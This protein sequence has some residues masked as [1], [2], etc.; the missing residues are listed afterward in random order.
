MR[1]DLKEYTMMSQN[2]FLVLVVELGIIEDE[3]D[4]R[5]DI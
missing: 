4:D 5:D 3:C 2:L 1:C